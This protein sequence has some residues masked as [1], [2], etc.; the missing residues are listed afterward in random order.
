M[1]YFEEH[2]QRASLNGIEF[3]IETR[4]TDRERSIARKLY[5][6]RDGQSTESTGREPRKYE[7]V[8]PLFVGMKWT[9]STPLFPETYQQLLALF[10]DPDLEGEV[11]YV[12]PFDGPVDV[13][14]PKLSDEMKATE[15]NG[16]RLHFTLEERGAE[17]QLIHT[18]PQADPRAQAQLQAEELDWALEEAELAGAA[19]L[20]S[21]EDGGVPLNESEMA[22]EEG[23]LFVSL[24]D[25]FFATL[26]AGAMAAD[27]IAAVV[28]VFRTRVDRVLQ[29]SATGEAQNWT[30]YYSCI[31]LSESVSAAGE[32]AS[33]EAPTVVEYELD[34]EASHYEV[35]MR[36]YGSADRADEIARRNPSRSPLVYPRG[37]VL[38][39]L[40]R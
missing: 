17:A 18:R 35:A 14:L 30:V 25:G 3:P 20:E 27:E 16:V 31:R 26:D 4:R 9:G 8:V 21:F 6:F 39:V 23:T 1:G 2:F 40:S 19:I 29:F 24:V 34:T 10:A 5:P 7:I 33:S 11:E 37:T 38:R 15:R 28:D 22:F 13:V 36:R 32:R 12:D